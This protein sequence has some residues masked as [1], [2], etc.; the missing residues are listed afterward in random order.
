[1][2]SADAGLPVFGRGQLVCGRYTSTLSSDSGVCGRRT[3]R[4][5]TGATRLRTII[6]VNLSTS[7]SEEG[8]PAFVFGHHRLRRDADAP[9]LR[10][11]ASRPRTE[12]WYI[13]AGFLRA[14]GCAHAL[15]PLDNARAPL[16]TTAAIFRWKDRAESLFRYMFASAKICPTQAQLFF[17]R[18]H[19]RRERPPCRHSAL[20]KPC[21]G[22]VPGGCGK[23]GSASTARKR[24]REA[25]RL[26]QLGH[27]AG[28]A[29]PWSGVALESAQ[30]SSEL[31]AERER[32]RERER[33]RGQ[34]D[35]P[36]GARRVWLLA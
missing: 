22:A 35:S 23:R 26:G 36:L 8:A 6:L 2:V 34:K 19:R 11:W 30:K 4:L 32:E 25:A 31:G 1:M 24:V 3:P 21:V 18:G 7:S 33:N 20:S 10:R 16:W 27:G 29:G 17:L 12:D 9:H 15:A 5:R 13:H 14:T 28:S